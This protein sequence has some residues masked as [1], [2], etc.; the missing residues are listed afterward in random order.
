MLCFSLCNNKYLPCFTKTFLV[1]LQEFVQLTCLTIPKPFHVI[2][3]VEFGQ[4][5]KRLAQRIEVERK[6]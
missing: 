5:R 3:K 4:T 6:V 2:G 1:L